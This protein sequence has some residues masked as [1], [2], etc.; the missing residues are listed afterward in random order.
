MFQW[1]IVLLL[2]FCFWCSAFDVLHLW[3]QTAPKMLLFS[4]ITS[5]AFL[6]F[7]FI[8]VWMWR[9]SYSILACNNAICKAGRTY[10]TLTVGHIRVILVTISNI[11]VRSPERKWLVTDAWEC[12]RESDGKASPS[13]FSFC[14]LLLSSPHKE[15]EGRS[16][17]PRE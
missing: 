17:R 16:R 6:S 7:C 3:Y 4:F 15:G 13:I 5:G 9:L 12:M 10:V 1:E 8:T 2:M 11:G 14:I